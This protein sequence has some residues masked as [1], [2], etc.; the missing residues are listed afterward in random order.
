MP[1]VSIGLPVF[2]G[3]RYLSVA[4]ESFLA[5]TFPDFELVICDNASTDRTQEICR[6]FACRDP[7]IRYHRN[8]SN[9]GPAVNFNLTFELSSG[10]YFKWAAHDDLCAPEFVE[11]CVDV[12]DRDP[13]AVL[14]Y[15]KAIVIDADGQEIKPYALKLPTD[16]PNPVERFEAL[17]R[18]H[19]CFEV[20]GLI[21]RAALLKT[22]LIGA[23]A[24]GDGV[25][26]ARLAILGRFEEIPEYLF[27]ARQHPGQS[28]AFLE[29][30][31]GPP[32]SEEYNRYAI[33][34][35]PKLKNR[36]LLPYWRICFELFRALFAAPI[37]FKDRISCYHCL[38]NWIYQRRH[39]LRAEIIFHA[40]RLVHF[41]PNTKGS[42]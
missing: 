2:N 22:R 38:K 36:M 41:I 33:W 10:D 1:R 23:H 25:L 39:L 15:P 37:R 34:F 12:L 6:S 14:A 30:R 18:G 4:I 13:G 5:Q 3:E 24:H 8:F 9:V 29:K 21:R 31:S 35:N 28:M 32:T 16:S 26:L 19:K 7:R 11:R 27:F 17:L 20:F 40:T 42:R